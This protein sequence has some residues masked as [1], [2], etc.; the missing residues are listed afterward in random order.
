MK[1]DRS[2]LIEK[3]TKLSNDSACSTHERASAKNLIK[4]FEVENFDSKI[5]TVSTQTSLEVS[6]SLPEILEDLPSMEYFKDDID[7]VDAYRPPSCV[8]QTSPTSRIGNFPHISLVR[9]LC[10]LK[11]V[12]GH[13]TTRNNYCYDG[14]GVTTEYGVITRLV[15]FLEDEE[16]IQE[17]G[18]HVMNCWSPREW[19][20]Y[21]EVG[22]FGYLRPDDLVRANGYWRP[23][24][25]WKDF[26][27]F[28]NNRI[29]DNDNLIKQ[30]KNQK[31]EKENKERLEKAK[32]FSRYKSR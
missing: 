15:V 11:Y 7:G 26:E 21:I 18:R 14:W 4:K 24:P 17:H 5:K 22:D 12:Y 16:C 6:K 29:I 27:R 8:T 3:L 25:W 13:Y 30:E 10:T 20:N 23:G 9:K 32:L 28:V 2:L 19:C 1:K 31:L